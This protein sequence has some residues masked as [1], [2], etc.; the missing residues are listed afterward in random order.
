M[1][2]GRMVG[3]VMSHNRTEAGIDQCI[4]E[5][6]NTAVVENTGVDENMRVD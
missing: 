5:A 1:L 6:G 3:L 4:E 2:L